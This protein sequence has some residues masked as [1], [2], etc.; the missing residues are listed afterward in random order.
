MLPADRATLP[1]DRVT[2]DSYQETLK[3]HLLPLLRGRKLVF[4]Q[5]NAPAHRA[6]T[7][8]EF[9]TLHAIDILPSWPPNSPDLNPIENLWAMV[10]KRIRIATTAS[11]AELQRV[12]EEKWHSIPQRVVDTLV[13]SFPRRLELCL[14]KEGGWIGY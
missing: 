12:I 7:T 13:E 14:E 2:A 3:T 11:A 10:K 6:K 1:S 8:Q 5:D 4:Q 9:A